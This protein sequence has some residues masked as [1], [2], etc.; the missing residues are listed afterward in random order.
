MSALLVVCALGLVEL[1]LVED[2]V[3]LLDEEPPPAQAPLALELPLL[4]AADQVGSRIVAIVQRRPPL[5]VSDDAGAT[6]RELGGGLRPGT[7]L[8]IDPDDPDTIAY[9]TADRIHVSRSGGVF[10]E[11]LELEL[12]AISRVHWRT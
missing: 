8:A 3:E 11:A 4:V 9:A 6:W 10:W 1:D 2:S 5:V 7:D 12:P